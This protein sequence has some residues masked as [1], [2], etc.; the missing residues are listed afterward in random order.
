M[1]TPVRRVRHRRARA[2]A[3]QLL[4]VVTG[5][6]LGLTLPRIDGGP[7]AP[8]R[9]VTELLFATAVG[10]VAAVALV[11]SL[12]F[13]VV[14]WVA[15]TFTPPPDPVPGRPDRV[16]D[17]RHRRRPGRV[18]HHRRLHHRPR[19]RHLARRPGRRDAARARDARG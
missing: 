11:F 10:L 14:Q 9:Q 8:A 6:G 5:I 18:L 1:N 13:L 17:L 4:C 15:T 19:Q 2:G 7:R 12:L 3:T 16:A